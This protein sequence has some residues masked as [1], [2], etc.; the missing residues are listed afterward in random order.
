MAKY[1]RF[2]NTSV[3]EIFDTYPDKIR[4]KLLDLRQLIIDTV[5]VN[6]EIG[7]IEETLK[8]GEPSYL[9]KKSNKGTTLR[10]DWKHNNPNHYA[11]YFNCRTSLIENIKARYGTTFKTIG[12]RAILFSLTETLPKK[13]LGDCIYMALTYH[14]LKKKGELIEV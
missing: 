9:P 11:M 3:K 8:W 14:L 2:T 10:I 12:H 4:P 6:P 7:E 13:A 1:H 5:M